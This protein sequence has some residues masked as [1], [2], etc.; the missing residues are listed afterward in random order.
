MDVLGFIASIIDSLAWPAAIVVLVVVLQAPL[1]KLLQEL[2]R[3][4]YEEVEI[5]FGREVQR[6]EDRAKMAGLHL[7]ENLSGQAQ[8]QGIRRKSS[9][10]PRTFRDRPSAWLGRLSSMS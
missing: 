7:P 4:R 6:L 3:F 1:R 10:T 2:T 9:P 5:D 8:K